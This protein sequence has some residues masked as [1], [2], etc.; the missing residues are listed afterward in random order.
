MMCWNWSATENM[1]TMILVIVFNFFTVSADF[2][3]LYLITVNLFAIEIV[4]KIVN[5]KIC[6]SLLIFRLLKSLLLNKGSSAI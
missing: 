1:S 2:V 6:V 3:N 5:C 4:R